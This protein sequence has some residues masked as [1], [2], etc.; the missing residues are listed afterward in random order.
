MI[1]S[2]LRNLIFSLIIVI[3]ESSVLS[4]IYFFPVT[5][6]FLLT[7]IVFISFANGQMLGISLA[8]FS[9]FI[10]DYIS[11]TP[12]GLTSFTLLVVSF[13]CGS[14]KRSF[15]TDNFL[16]QALVIAAA[17]FAK[18]A[19]L[20]FLSFFYGKSIQTYDLTELPFW[21]EMAANTFLAPFCFKFF[22]RFLPFLKI[23]F[24]VEMNELK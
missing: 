1:L 5:P 12:F 6:D 8:F 9:G 3:F 2:L 11:M 10:A 4:N 7:F 20:V 13:V 22:S 14:M 24:E 15:S 21:I 17:T 23:S 19:I 16:F 18:S